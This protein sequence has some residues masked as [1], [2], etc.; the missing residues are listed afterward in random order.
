[1]DLQLKLIQ[2]LADG[3]FHPEDE[4]RKKL[5]ISKNTINQYIH[6]ISFL[7]LEIHH[8]NSMGYIIPQGLELLS[9]EQIKNHLIPSILNQ[10]NILIFPKMSSTNQFLLDRRLEI[11]SHSIVLAEYQSKGRG[12]SQK[13]WFSPFGTNLYFSMLWKIDK[14]PLA[15]KGLSLATGV[16]VAHTLERYGVSQVQLKWPNDI[17]HANQKLG[18]I[19][20]EMAAKTHGPTHMIIGVGLNVSMSMTKMIPKNWTDVAKI[21]KQRPNKNQLAA[22]LIE[23]IVKMLSIFQH[24]GM[25]TFKNYWE[26]LDAYYN[27]RVIVLTANESYAGIAKGITEE[28][29]LRLIDDSHSER[30]FSHGE[31]SL[32]LANCQQTL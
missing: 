3:K 24:N 19:L 32:R 11:P 21:I 16:A 26:A 30:H 15:L 18:G 25:K 22:H 7:E 28:G 5:G 10:V 20:I 9:L 27:Q 1:M 6:E 23:E 2:L 17:L 13:P 31:V 4:I 29:E 8:M 14:D 12:R